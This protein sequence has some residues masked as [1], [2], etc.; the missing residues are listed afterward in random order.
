MP[1]LMVTN[2]IN[3]NVQLSYWVNYW[4]LFRV[5]SELVKSVSSLAL[6]QPNACVFFGFFATVPTHTVTGPEFLNKV[7]NVVCQTFKC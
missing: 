7:T 1:D 3:K 4:T 2:V 6:S 5:Y